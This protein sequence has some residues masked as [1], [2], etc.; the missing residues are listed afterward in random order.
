MAISREALICIYY[1]GYDKKMVQS[2]ELIFDNEIVII[3]SMPS[4]VELSVQIE[5][6]T[7]YYVKFIF[8]LILTN[9]NICSFN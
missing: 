6:N 5:S 2:V 7:V 1:T 8:T 3:D 4:L 9:S